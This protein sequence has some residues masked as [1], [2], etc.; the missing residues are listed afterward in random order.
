LSA[1]MYNY[2]VSLTTELLRV[3]FT[4]FFEYICKKMNLSLI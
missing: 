3:S 4:Y 1:I 2:V